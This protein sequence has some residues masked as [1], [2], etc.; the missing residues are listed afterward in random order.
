MPPGSL[1]EAAM[2]HDPLCPWKWFQHP[3]GPSVWNCQCD[4]IAKARADELKRVSN[5]LYSIGQP[6]CA[7]LI[8]VYTR[9]VSDE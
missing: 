5:Y 7:N 2:K 1:E 3:G 8:D 9:E 4:L 6:G